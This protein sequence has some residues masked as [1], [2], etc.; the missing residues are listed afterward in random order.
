[1]SQFRHGTVDVNRI[2]LHYVEA[3]AGPVIVFCH[4]FPEFWYSWRHQLRFFADNGFHAIALDMRGHGESDVPDDIADY[5]V[6]HTVGDVI[7][8]L[9]SLQ[10]EHAVIVGHDAGTTTAYHAALM[11]PDRIVGVAGLS[12]P[13][14]PRGHLS[15]IEALENEVPPEFYMLY[16]QAPGVAEADLEKNPRHS[17][18]RLFYANSGMNPGS[19]IMMMATKERGLIDTLPTAPESLDF[20]GE[21]EMDLYE[22]A[23]TRTGFSGGLNGY[24]VFH[25]N[26]EL[27]SPWNGMALPIPN[28]FIGGSVD[29]VLQF[30][31]FRDAAEAMEE[32]HILEDAGHW[33]QSERTPDV[34]DILLRFCVRVGNRPA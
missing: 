31:G 24:R 18:R 32:F 23:F 8:L 17:L 10:I 9:D 4:G 27:T 3:G 20:L 28:L 11:R 14:M 33:I 29:T 5:D 7:G 19:P 26:W 12:V 1:M 30:P 21:D 34:N 25:R 6:L 2:R 22:A 15:M 16:F 13:F